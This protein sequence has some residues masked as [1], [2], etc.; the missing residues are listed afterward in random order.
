MLWKEHV[1]NLIDAT[2]DAW[3]KS[4][5]AMPSD[6]GPSTWVPGHGGIAKAEDVATFRN[7]LA[8]LRASITRERSAGKSNDAIVKALLPGL[9][10]KYGKWGFFSDYA[11]LDIEQTADELAGKKR[12]PTPVAPSRGE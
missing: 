11:K 5:D 3:I 12:V 8:D 4:L 10:S 6:Y 2:T 1:P 9:Q 7:Y